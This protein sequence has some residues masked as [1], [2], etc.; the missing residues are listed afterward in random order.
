MICMTASRFVCAV[1]YWGVHMLLHITKKKYW[2]HLSCYS[3]L[4]DCILVQQVNNA[5][6]YSSK[7]HLITQNSYLFKMFLCYLTT[8]HH[9]TTNSTIMSWLHCK[10]NQYT[11][12]HRACRSGR[13]AHTIWRTAVCTLLHTAPPGPFWLRK[14]VWRDAGAPPPLITWYWSTSRLLKGRP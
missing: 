2:S 14:T 4:Q 5:H 3:M 13:K 9:E 10:K 1:F 12:V 6:K 11:Y 7:P 8:S